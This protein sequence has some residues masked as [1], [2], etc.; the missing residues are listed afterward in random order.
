MIAVQ[1]VAVLIADKQIV[2]L[3][4]FGLVGQGFQLVLY[5]LIKGLFLLDVVV[6]VAFGFPVILFIIGI[7]TS[8][9]YAVIPNG[10]IGRAYQKPCVSTVPAPKTAVM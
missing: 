5:D 9:C 2:I 6:Q 8:V 1:R 10:C 3:Q 4:A 7:H